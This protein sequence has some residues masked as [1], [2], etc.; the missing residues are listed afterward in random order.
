MKPQ[1]DLVGTAA[2]LKCLGSLGEVGSRTL[3]WKGRLKLTLV[4]RHYWAP[5]LFAAAVAT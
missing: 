1:P 5:D 4:L 3:Q 2:A